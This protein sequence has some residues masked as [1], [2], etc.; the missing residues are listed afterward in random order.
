MELI[1][2][3]E[4]GKHSGYSHGVKVTANY[5]IFVA[6]QVG[7][8]DQAR[9]V[10]PDFAPQFAKAL[11]NVL[12]VIRTAGGQPHHVVRLTIYV[13]DRSEYLA[14]LEAIGRAYQLQ[15]GRHYP[16]MTV[17]EVRALLEEGARVE[18][19]ATAAL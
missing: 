4:L 10:S 18:L 2:P 17:V 19:E 9:I 3:T 15:M 7:W 13:L 5:L 16:A 11:E 12:V 8:D 6:G 1:N 14:N